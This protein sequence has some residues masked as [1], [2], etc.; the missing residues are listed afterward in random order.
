MPEPCPQ[1]IRDYVRVFARAKCDR[2]LKISFHQSGMS[3]SVHARCTNVG[4]GGFHARIPHKLEIDQLVSI[5]FSVKEIP[6]T[7]QASVRHSSGFDTGF[8]FVAPGEEQRQA[9]TQ[10]FME[11][12]NRAE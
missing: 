6:V 5:E 1:P 4:P 9:I 8:E 11:D 2:K 10:F 12:M 7:L 3:L